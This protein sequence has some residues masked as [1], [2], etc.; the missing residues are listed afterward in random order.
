MWWT[1]LGLR[2]QGALWEGRAPHFK[3]VLAYY[4]AEE[5][6]V[7]NGVYNDGNWHRMTVEVRVASIPTGH[8]KLWLDGV[9]IYDDSAGGEDR[10]RTPYYTKMFGNW[11]REVG[12]PPIDPFQLD[13][14]D[15][16]VWKTD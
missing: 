16:Y 11:V 15:F 8:I 9:L 4:P 6:P 14:D 1:N 10:T 12:Q 7:W 13:L 3:S 2:Y 5:Y